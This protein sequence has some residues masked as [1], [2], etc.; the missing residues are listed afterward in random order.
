MTRRAARTDTGQ[1]EIVAALRAVGCTVAVTSDVG[2]GFPDLVVGLANRGEG[3]ERLNLL[4]EIKDGSKP[5]SAR[6]LT[7]AEQAWHAA[8][9]GQ[10]AVVASVDE[11]LAAVGAAE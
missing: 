11:A 10:V 7:P 1:A 9:R 2:G 3:P 6:R 4:L 8:W 5:P